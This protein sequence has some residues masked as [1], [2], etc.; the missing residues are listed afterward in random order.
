MGIL[1]P[2]RHVD[3]RYSLYRRIDLRCCHSGH[4]VVAIIALLITPWNL[5]NSP[6][7]VNIFLGAVGAMLGTLFGIIMADYFILRKQRVV[8]GD[9]YRKDGYYTFNAGWNV[10]AIISFLVTSIPTIVI[11]L[12]P[13]RCAATG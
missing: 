8:L 12:V 4:N 3:V 1:F 9:L 10:K 11:S 7:V 6:I 5:F 13:A 2:L